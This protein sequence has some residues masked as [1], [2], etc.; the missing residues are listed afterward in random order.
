MPKKYERDE[1]ILIGQQQ[2][3]HTLRPLDIWITM[4][5]S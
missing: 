1:I 3:L 2:T 4:E 5:T